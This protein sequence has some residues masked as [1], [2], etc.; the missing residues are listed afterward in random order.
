MH[1]KID[2]I[3]GVADGYDAVA[4]QL[5]GHRGFM[6]KPLRGCAEEGSTQGEKQGGLS[7]TR[8]SGRSF[9]SS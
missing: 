7:F 8:G 6:G 5:A 9:L 1:M 3:G 2:L 4:P